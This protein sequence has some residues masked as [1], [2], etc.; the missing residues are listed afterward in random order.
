MTIIGLPYDTE[1]SIMEM[2]DW[3]R[4]VS[5]YQTANLLTPLPATINFPDPAKGWPGLI[6]LD[7]DGSILPE[8]KMRPYHLYTGRQFVHYD[9]RWDME[10]SREIYRK[11]TAKLRPIDTLYSRIYRMIQS[12]ASRGEVPQGAP[13][14]IGSAVA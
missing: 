13:T 11:Y 10:A 12:R 14:R 3:V 4:G 5:D 8:G 6:P 2:A 9:E 7:E 1:Q